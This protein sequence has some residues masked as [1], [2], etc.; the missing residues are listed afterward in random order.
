MF[1]SSSQPMI[2]IN[3]K[4]LLKVLKI[5]NHTTKCIFINMLSDKEFSLDLSVDI[6]SIMKWKNGENINKAMPNLSKEIKEIFYTGI[7]DSE[8]NKLLS[9][10]H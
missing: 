5:D 6:N 7:L 1:S 3:Y 10:K 8:F 9:I 4:A 2:S